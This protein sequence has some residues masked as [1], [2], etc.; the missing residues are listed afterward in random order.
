MK[1]I[2]QKYMTPKEVC[3]VFN[4]VQSTLYTWR[5]KGLFPNTIRVER[6]VRLLTSDVLEAQKFVTKSR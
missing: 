1:S 2:T 6:T 5:L 4:I 3:E